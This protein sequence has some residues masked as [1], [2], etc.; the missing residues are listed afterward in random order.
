MSVLLVLI[1]PRDR[2]RPRAPGAEGEAPPRPPGEFSWVLSTDGRTQAGSGRSEPARWPRADAVVAVLA[3]ADVSWHRIT[4]P[5]APA[6]RLRAAL[7]GVL[8]EALLED[9]DRLHFALGPGAQP[10]LPGWVA[11]VDRPWL[12]ATLAA[13]E[14]GGRAVERVLALGEPGRR[15]GHFMSQGDA[16]WLSLSQD[17]GSATLR[18][19]GTL[20]RALLPAVDAGALRWTAQPSAASD[21]E[22]WLG[23]SVTVL[24]D[25][26]RA[27]Q[28]LGS[29]WNLR[30]FDLAPRHRGLRALRQGWRHLLGPTWRPVRV[31]LVVLVSLQLVGLNAVAWQQRR[32]LDDR[33]AA[34]V[35]L[36][37]SSHPQ[38]RTVLDAPLQMARETERLRAVA[39]RAGDGDL[40]VLLAA[41]AQAWPD[42]A[43]PVQA[44]QFG[45]GRLTLAAPGWDGT[46]LAQFRDRLR[47][48]GLDAELAEGRITLARRSGGPA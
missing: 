13:L 23:A 35:E 5:K 8:E 39:G 12:A 42:A 37:R 28:A 24:T 32:A 18:V 40:E 36:L 27:L 21:A 15:A 2:Q 33:R 30:Q 26:E 41:A 9:E 43:A 38:V 10:G 47:P 14:A 16:L 19:Q 4:V 31:G 6:A 1:P 29:E 11:V 44:L 17:N 46:A 20:A 22:R 7:A 45:N 34:M 3:D 48:A 25:P